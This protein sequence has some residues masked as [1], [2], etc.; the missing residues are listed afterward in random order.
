MSLDVSLMRTFH[1]SYDNCKTWKEKIESVYENNI[2]HNLNKMADAAGIY[3]VIWR[4]EE[5]NIYKA[6]ELISYLEVG[7]EELRQN[8]EQYE[9]FNPPNGWG[10]YEGL[11]K[12]VE[13]Y[14]EACR[15][16]PDANI[17]VCR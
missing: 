13:K 10:S 6:G 1:V 16:Y 3:G 8:P 2:T 11:V 14:L 9:T 12:F 15:K 5:N 7:L 4:P 17:Y